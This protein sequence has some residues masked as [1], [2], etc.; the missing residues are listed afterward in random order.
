MQFRQGDVFI[1]R[2]DTLP[3]GAVPVNGPVIL[4]DGEAT[5]HAHRI[6]SRSAKMFTNGGRRFVRLGK[7]ADVVHE[8]HGAINLAAGVYEVRRQVEYTP[9]AIRNVAD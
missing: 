5:G 9:G 3:S 8:E 7:P 2:I 6:K 4:A 1:V